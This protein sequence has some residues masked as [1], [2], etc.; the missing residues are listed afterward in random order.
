MGA[1]E[2][3]ATIEDFQLFIDQPSCSEAVAWCSVSFDGPPRE[4]RLVQN[5]CCRGMYI[6]YYCHLTKSAC[7]FS[8]TEH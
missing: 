2:T 1:H 5:S 7:G 8:L 3:M 4:G 6:W